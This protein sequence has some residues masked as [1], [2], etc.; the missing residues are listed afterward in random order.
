MHIYWHV[1]NKPDQTDTA[2]CDNVPLRLRFNNTVF[3]SDNCIKFNKQFPRLDW[4]NTMQCQRYTQ[5]ITE[6]AA[7]HLSD[8]EIN[9]I[10]DKA[11]AKLQLN[12][13]CDN[14][15]DVIHK[16]VKRV[17]DQIQ[18]SN[19]K[20]KKSWWTSDCKLSRDRQRFWH[21]IWTSAGRP[22]SGELYSCYKHAKKSYRYACRNAVN[23]K[24]QAMYR[25]LN[26]H[27]CTRNMKKF[28]NLVR[29]NK[30]SSHANSSDITID[31]LC[32][33]YTKRFAEPP[34]KSSNKIKEAE[35]TVSSHY[36]AIKMKYM[37]A[38]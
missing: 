11:D 26:H 1:Y 18:G 31:K 34:K 30:P 9:S 8:V 7:E 29:L 24:N 2:N 4:S 12:M 15:Q 10:T 20:G 25:Q 35:E 27:L 6:L 32:E 36:N 5:N 22:R 38:V 37:E 33:F 21:K 19:S 17:Q 13:L 28:W 3:T 14:I 23:C 16:A